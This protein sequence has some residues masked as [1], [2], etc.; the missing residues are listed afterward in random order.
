M[1]NRPA[2][3]SALAALVFAVS[4]HAAPRA[5]NVSTSISAPAGVFY[6][7]NARYTVQVS[8]VGNATAS[9]VAITVQLPRTNTSPT[10]HVLGDLGAMDPRCTRVGTT[11]QC[12]VTNH[13]AGRS[14]SVYFDLAIP[15]SA[16]P[17]SLRANAVTAG[18]SNTGN[19]NA[20]GTLS[21][22]AQS[23]AVNPVR[24]TL[25]RHCS[26]T[27]LISFFE[28][29]LYPSSLMEHES[30]LNV[31]GSIT[32]LHIGSSTY[33]GT[34]TQPAPNRL[35][36]TYTDGADVVATFD[37]YGVDGCFEGRTTF[38]NS[39]YVSMYQVCL[40]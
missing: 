11:L 13:R 8:N 14:A 4:A 16:A 31:D 24:Q 36:M 21:L 37:G 29:E 35:Q 12:T 9:S 22:A 40:R 30:Q 39:T 5:P 7:A 32:F 27:N 17:V 38:P 15:Y 26:G 23:I 33:G 2:A 34:W 25:V 20:S 18:D 10:V 3:L 19:N 28:C 6:G 1:M